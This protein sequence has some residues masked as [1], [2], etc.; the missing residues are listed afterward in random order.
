MT[1]TRRVAAI[2]IVHATATSC[3][4][5]KDDAQGMASVRYSAAFESATL[6]KRRAFL[7]LSSDSIALERTGCFGACG[8][9]RLVIT[10][11][12]S[13]R[14]ASRTPGDTGRTETR[15]IHPARFESLM[16]SAIS[17][18]FMVLPSEIKKG[19]ARCGP[20]A[21]DFPS[22]TVTLYAG[23]ETKSVEDYLGCH[24]APSAL[25]EFE[26]E[27]DQVAKSDEWVR[28]A[29]FG[30]RIDSASAVR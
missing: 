24:W 2:G 14:F 7:P 11:S 10:K 8:A 13:V 6:D 22:A 30:T 29:P 1:A 9:Y 15:Q 26:R 12:G 25:R 23:R 3:T 21:T 18:H 20:S 27:I 16:Y 17:T 28:E 4:C 19:E 5:G